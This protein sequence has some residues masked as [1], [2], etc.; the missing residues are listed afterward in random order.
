M[1]E[2][3]LTVH[4]QFESK[5]V[6]VIEIRSGYHIILETNVVRGRTDNE[7]DFCYGTRSNIFPLKTV[8]NIEI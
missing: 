6:T 4:H 5:N 8:T 7:F 2:T 1:A 3:R